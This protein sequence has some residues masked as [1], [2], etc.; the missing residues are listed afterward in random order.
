M[1]TNLKPVDK[2]EVIVL[3]DN[4]VDFSGS[5]HVES[6]QQP[7]KW[8]KEADHIYLWAGHG[9]S[10]LVRT[11]LEKE[12]HEVL[13]DTGPS[14]EILEHNVRSLKLDL[15]RVE[16]IVMSHG[17]WDHFGGLGAALREIGR[18]S[19]PVY[20]HPRMLTPRR[21]ITETDTSCTIRNFLPIATE[22]EIMNM[23]GAVT[24][25]DVPLTLAGDT[26]LRTGEIPRVMEYEKGMSGHQALVEGEWIDDTAVIDDCSLIINVAEKG[27]V[28]LTG[29]GHAGVVNSIREAIRLTD[30]EEV[31]A[32][33]GGVHL[34]SASETIIR[35]TVRDLKD[36]GPRVIACGHCTGWRAEHAMSHEFGNRYVQSSVGTMFV[37]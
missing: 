11:Y 10:L 17:H 27:L 25:T 1:A 21:V 23:Q 18:N 32:V 8:T 14:E 16:S 12:R 5:V 3:V 29:C 30:T 31:L 15:T 9:L 6:A 36:I 13:Y 37:F 22:E 33:I 19:V 28:I 20:L 7:S 35:K 2:A 34:M 24:K 4:V 26:L